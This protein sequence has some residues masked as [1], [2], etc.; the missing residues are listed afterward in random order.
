MASADSKFDDLFCSVLINLNNKNVNALIAR[1]LWGF[2]CTRSLIINSKFTMR[3]L[4]F[5]VHF[6]SELIE[7]NPDNSLA[8][9]VN[10]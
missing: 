2:T 3:L 10:L 1:E 7:V 6:V 8:E 5:L 4:T 9:C